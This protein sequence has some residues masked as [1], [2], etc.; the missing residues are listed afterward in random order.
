MLDEGVPVSVGHVFESLGQ[1]VI[2][3]RDVLPESVPDHVVAVAALTNNAILVA[4]DEDMRRIARKYG[5]KGQD[6][7]YAKLNLIHLCCDSVLASKRADHAFSF[8]EFE[9]NF[10]IKKPARRM[11]IEIG[12][13]YLK[14][15]R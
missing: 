9:W 11:W 14:T 13:H 7:R 4:I 6:P 3:Y 15:H 1:E 5:Q 10:N 8:I 12:A 2:F